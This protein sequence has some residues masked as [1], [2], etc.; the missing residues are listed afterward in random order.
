M[1]VIM[2]K[3]ELNQA[4]FRIPFIYVPN[5]AI[6]LYSSSEISCITAIKL[7]VYF[8]KKVGK[9]IAESIY[10]AGVFSNG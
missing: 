5:D 4:I 2:N 8:P 1:T 7:S 10:V 9:A 3:L 6:N